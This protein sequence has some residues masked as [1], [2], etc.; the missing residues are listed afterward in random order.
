MEA[1]DEVGPFEVPGTDLPPAVPF[2]CVSA[3]C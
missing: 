2:P 3:C 1:E